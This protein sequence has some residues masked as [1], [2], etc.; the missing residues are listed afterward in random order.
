[1]EIVEV[2]EE[3]FESE[4]LNSAVPTLVDFYA[5]W[6]GPCRMLRPVLEDLAKEKST[7]KFVSLNVDEADMLAAKY[8]VQSIPCVI[9]FNK[10]KEVNRSIGFRPKDDFETMLRE[11]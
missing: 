4:V 8:G 7:V 3:N 11:F 6:C 5:N 9:L 10:G 1:M 2:N